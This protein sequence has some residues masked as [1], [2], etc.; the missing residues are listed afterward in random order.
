MH[1]PTTQFSRLITVLAFDISNPSLDSLFIAWDHIAA[2]YVNRLGKQTRAGEKIESIRLLAIHDAVISILGP[3]TGFI[4]NE[5]STGTSLSAAL[6]ATAQASHDILANAFTS[7]QDLADLDDLLEESL[8]LIP[9]SR[10]K[11]VGSA[12]GSASAAAFIATFGSLA[13]IAEQQAV[14]RET[15]RSSRES[16]PFFS[17]DRANLLRSA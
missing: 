17:Y 13:V 2:R 12:T 9:D 7:P 11:A 3:G 14:P 8:A 10:E 4:F 16:A 1:L 5:R 15:Y 6:A